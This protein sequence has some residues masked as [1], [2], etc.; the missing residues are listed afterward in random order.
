MAEAQATWK[1]LGE[2]YVFNAPALFAW[3]CRA[4]LWG[5][6]PATAKTALD[7]LDATGVHGAA[8]EATRV[9]CRAG[10]AALEGRAAEATAMYRDA[11]RAWRDLDVG[12][13]GALTAAE[14]A[15]LLD[16]ADP[17]VADAGRSA[18]EVFARLRATLLL[19]RLDAA[20]A[21][22]KPARSRS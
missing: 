8:I 6:D 11:L 1:G 19:D 14:M 5:R 2:R 4:S 15:F 22:A 21:T 20:L 18:R 9:T 13:E 10:I 3:A 16:P 7:A 12:L 17:E